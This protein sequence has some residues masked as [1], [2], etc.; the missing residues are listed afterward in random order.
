MPPFQFWLELPLEMRRNIL[1]RLAR[2]DIVTT[3]QKEMEEMYKTLIGLLAKKGKDE[4]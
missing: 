4:L 2:E 3:S 1:E